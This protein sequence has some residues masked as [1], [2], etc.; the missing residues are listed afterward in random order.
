MRDDFSQKTKDTLA[1]RVNFLCSNPKCLL[2]TSG[3]H[4][5]V[6][7]AV[8]KGVAAHI[9]AASPGGMRYNE[10]L[11]ADERKG[12]DNGIW[13]CQNCAKLID[14]DE[15]QFPIAL[16][17]EWKN[18]AEA[19]ASHSVHTNTPLLPP[20]L[21]PSLRL[22]ASYSGGRT[23]TCVSL[24]IFNTGDTPRFLSYW[25][26][27]WS[28]K[29]REMTA[30]RECVRGTLPF[31]LQG[32]DNYSLEIHLGASGFEGISSLGVMDGNNSRFEVPAGQLKA[33]AQDAE[34]YSV[35]QPKPVGPKIEPDVLRECVLDIN[36]KLQTELTGAKSL[37]VD[38]TN[39][40]EVTVPLSVGRI[41]WEYDPPREHSFG[42]EANSSIKSAQQLGGRISLACRSGLSDGVAPGATV[43]FYVPREIAM[44]L[45]ETLLGDVPDENIAVLIG[46]KSEVGWK[47]TEDGIPDAVRAYAEYLLKS[48]E[49]AHSSPANRT[50]VEDDFGR[51]IPDFE[52]ADGTNAPAETDYTY[53]SRETT[54]WYR[55]RESTAALNWEKQWE[56]LREHFDSMAFVKRPI[57]CTM[58]QR[59]TPGYHLNPLPEPADWQ[60]DLH[61]GGGGLSREF[62]ILKTREQTV[63]FSDYAI[64]DANGSPIC[65]SAN[66]AVAIRFGLDRMYFLQYGPNW[67]NEDRDHPGPSLGELTDECAKLLFVLPSAV[68][69]SIWV[70]WLEGF[71]RK[72][73]AG[74][75]LWY[76][77]LF[78]L[79]WQGQPGD[80]LYTERHAPVTNGSVGLSGDGLFPRIP[81]AL[82]FAAGRVAHEH[83]IPVEIVSKL[84]NVVSASIAAIDEILSRG[85]RSNESAT[86]E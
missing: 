24:N 50:W 81:P 41:E 67:A 61:S 26:V 45:T 84:D 75:Y 56:R 20:P 28:G 4:S 21:S 9:S 6:D 40:S 77:A 7:K 58:S 63:I 70:N 78:E 19:K 14:S 22:S 68:A 15:A 27:E 51:E 42:G 72:R 36:V 23:G 33:V 31:R 43:Q 13:L 64:R 52:F 65:N 59:R 5:D 62:S 2:A 73:N 55:P 32:Q 8:S 29:N 38:V 18:A 85:T 30:S 16:L 25:Y 47:A 53:V 82:G 12:T 83:G 60:E 80:R 71:D 3:P 48:Q 37:V 39:Q 86:K 10:T 54:T 44:V 57:A 66:D 1:R 35:L 74:S 76:D 79:A 69:E 46:T 34:R 17:R 11:S 49:L